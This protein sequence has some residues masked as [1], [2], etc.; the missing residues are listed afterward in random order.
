MGIKLKAA[1]SVTELG[2]YLITFLIKFIPKYSKHDTIFK[3]VFLR[4]VLLD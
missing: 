1:G 3:I 4:L 2:I